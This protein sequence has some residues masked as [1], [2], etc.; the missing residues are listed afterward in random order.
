MNVFLSDL[1]LHLCTP[2]NVSSTGS[3]CVSSGRPQKDFTNLS[4]SS[5]KRRAKLVSG[6]YAIGERPHLQILH[7]PSDSC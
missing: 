2:D 7:N 4:E 3:T 5:K 1:H 6:K